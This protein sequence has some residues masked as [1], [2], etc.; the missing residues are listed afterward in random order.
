MLQFGHLTKYVTYSHQ[1][2]KKKNP[3]KQKINYFL[4]LEKHVSLIDKRKRQY[5][6][7]L[8]LPIKS[9]IKAN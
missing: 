7:A 8:L 9:K 2:K 4:F 6:E 5:I 3:S 1:I